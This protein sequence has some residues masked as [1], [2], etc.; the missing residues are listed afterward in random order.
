M[1]RLLLALT[2]ANVVD[3]VPPAGRPASSTVT[4]CPRTD[5]ADDTAAPS[6]PAPTTSTRMA[7][8]LLGGQR[9]DVELGTDDTRPES[10][11]QA[12]CVDRGVV[13]SGRHAECERVCKYETGSELARG[14][15]RR[16]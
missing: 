3:D 15:R 12:E 10:V 16:L 4:S 9:R 6:M 5:N 11:D 8:L 1:G 14:R 13:R 2:H 7:V